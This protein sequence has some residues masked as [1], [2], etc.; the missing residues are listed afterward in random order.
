[1]N[2]ELAL[3]QMLEA[4]PEELAVRG[5]SD[6]ASH[7]AGCERCRAVASEMLAGQEVLAKNLRTWEAE[8]AVDT[9]LQGVRVQVR[10]DRRRA[11]TRVALLPLA[12]AAVFTLVVTSDMWRSVPP[13]PSPPTSAIAVERRP[14]FAIPPVT[15]A[16]LLKTDNPKITVV[17]F[18]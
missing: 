11:R 1:M 14:S 17:W 7:L 4:D 10:A 2:C 6:L 5:E 12:A 9:V 13:A 8:G 16:V 18:Y 3:E 15:N